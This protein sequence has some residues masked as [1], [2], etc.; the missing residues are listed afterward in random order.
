MAHSYIKH[1]KDFETNGSKKSSWRSLPP[2]PSVD[3]LR[4]KSIYHSPVQAEIY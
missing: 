2:S 4:P 3:I 1:L